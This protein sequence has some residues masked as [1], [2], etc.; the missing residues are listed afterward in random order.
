MDTFAAHLQKTV[1][2]MRLTIIGG[3]NMGGSAAMGFAKSGKIRP[4]EITVSDLNP[5]TIQKFK[6]QGLNA[7]DDNS[8]AVEGADVVII[9]VKPWL[10]ETI[11]ND[12]KRTMDY[13]H[14]IVVCFAAGIT[15]QQ[16]LSW[17]GTDRDGVA[18]QILRVIP[19]IAIEILECMAFI[20]PI[21]A[22]QDSIEIVRNLFCSVGEALVVG[23]KQLEAGMALASCGLAYAMRY[24]RA[25]AEGGVELGMY[26]KEAIS[27]VC[28]TV[29]GAANLITAHDSHPEAEIDKVTTP[30]GVTIKGLNEMEAA[31]FTSAVIKGLMASKA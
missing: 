28:Q 10:V 25:A 15:S 31:G 4:D 5:S 20:S 19:N 21:N 23:E 12:I 26:P 16:L 11:V 24:I 14:Q 2:N 18:P 7:T 27:I 9:A 1:Q 22:H 6:E 17:F 30:G 13:K 3:G 29:I 8:K